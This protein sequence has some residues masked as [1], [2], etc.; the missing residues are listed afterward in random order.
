MMMPYR[1]CPAIEN[2]PCRSTERKYTLCESARSPPRKKFWVASLIAL[3]I[4]LS[5][6]GGAG[7]YAAI[8]NRSAG[9]IELGPAAVAKLH[10]AA[11]YGS[12]HDA[13]TVRMRAHE[14]ADKL[15]MPVVDVTVGFATSKRLSLKRDDLSGFD[16]DYGG[17]GPLLRVRNVWCSEVAR[18]V[19]L[20][21]GDEIVGVD[22]YPM[23]YAGLAYALDPSSP[24]G[25]ILEVRRN[26]LS[27][28]YAIAFR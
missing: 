28:L 12:P 16:L 17:G 18:T 13:A 26:G 11:L 14:L 24:H 10:Y 21:N 8:E 1:V 20:A 23:S 9:N 27:I 22:G 4:A 25:T 5:G 19:G 15:Q 7:A 2:E 6:F 3:G